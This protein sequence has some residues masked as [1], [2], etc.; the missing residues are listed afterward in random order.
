MAQRYGGKYSPGGA[1]D[2]GGASAQG[3]GGRP[4]DAPRVLHA[5]VSPTGAR[6]NVLFFPALVLLLTTFFDGA[7]GMA[8]GLLGAGIWT[9][10]AWLTREGLK[11]EDAYWQRTVAKR[12][13]LPRKILA[14][15]LFGAGAVAAGLAHGA[16]PV[17]AALYAV[18]AAVLHL[19]AFGPDPLRDKG[20]EGIDQFQQDRVARVVDEAET[21]LGEMRDAARRARDR[22]VEDRIAQFADS[23]REMIRTVEE[24]PRDLTAARRYLGV[25]L[26]GARDATVKFADIQARS[27]DAEARADYLLLLTDMEETYAAK[28]RKLLSDSNADLAIEIDVLRDRL[29]REGVHLDR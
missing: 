2:R 14:S 1:S 4:A 22:Q 26:M 28:T 20:L 3:A 16:D 9:L 25:Y 17:A 19:T 23:V 29:D 12:P 21:Y 27:A 11:A 18:M 5:R 6:S 13:A 8:L 7:T 15:A 10:G 24:D